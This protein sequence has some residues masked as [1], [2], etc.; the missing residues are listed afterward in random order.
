MFSKIPY[1]C[2]V[3]MYGILENSF[4]VYG[5]RVPSSF[6]NPSF[7]SGLCTAKLCASSVHE[8]I[9]ARFWMKNWK[10]DTFGL[11]TQTYQYT[12]QM[13]LICCFCVL[14]FNN[15]IYRNYSQ[16]QTNPIVVR[17][18]YLEVMNVWKR[19]W[20]I[21]VTTVCKPLSAYFLVWGCFS[22]S[23]LVVPIKVNHNAT[24]Q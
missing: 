13:F 16:L 7:E 23:G 4:L 15:A 5:W 6:S 20:F 11:K 24:T 18:E 14:F 19:L 2:T 9:L 21:F 22:C 10:R 12:D 3:H 8:L 17:W 1:M